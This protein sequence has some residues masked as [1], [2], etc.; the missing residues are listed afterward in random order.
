MNKQAFLTQLR[1]ALAG[2][3]QEEIEERLAFYGEMMDDRIEDGLTE[4]A[5]VAE[6]GPVEQIVAQTLAEIP[7]PKLVVE[8]M[9]PARRLQTWEIVLIILGFPLW[10]PLLIAGFALLFS[11]YVVLWTLVA[12]LWVIEGAFIFAAVSSTAAGFAWI[13][14]GNGTQSLLAICAGAVLAGLAIFLF[15]G[16]RAATRGAA[17]LTKKI[18]LGVKSL[19]LRKESRDSAAR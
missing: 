3:P 8:R 5:A 17:S 6:I 16:S 13:F 4:A 1:D 18:A 15:F 2:L 10:F 14:H 9:K 12:V 19:F 7:L 11:V